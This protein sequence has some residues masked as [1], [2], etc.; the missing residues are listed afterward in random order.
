MTKKFGIQK[1]QYNLCLVKT[2]LI[3]C[4]RVSLVG[5][6][7]QLGAF[8]TA[9]TDW[10]IVPAPGDYDDGEFGGMKTGRETEVLG[11][12]LSQRHFVHHKST[13]PDPGSNPGSSVGK[14][15]TNL[16]LI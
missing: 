9:A 11:E 5:G 15:A 10:L 16:I 1:I 14:P 13:W 12:S 7:V 2:V 4:G 8:G 3:F 6:E